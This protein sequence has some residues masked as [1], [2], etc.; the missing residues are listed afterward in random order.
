MRPAGLE[1]A[2]RRLA[3]L[4][5]RPA[6]GDLLGPG[7][8]QVV[9]RLQRLDALMGGLGQERL[10]DI[11]VEPFLLPPPFR[12]TGQSQL[13]LW[14]T[15]AGL[16]GELLPGFAACAFEAADGFLVAADFGGDGFEAAA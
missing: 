4:G 15:G 16:A 8:E 10:P 2:D 13:I 3:G 14:I 9:Q 6:V 5:V 1:P 12:L 11:A 7:G